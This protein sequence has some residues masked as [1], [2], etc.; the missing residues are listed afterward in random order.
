MRGRVL[1]SGCLVVAGLLCLQV[2]CA[3][4]GQPAS[5]QPI[6]IGVSAPLTG[7]LAVW[8]NNTLRGIQLAADEVNAAGGVSGRKIELVV[9]DSRCEPEEAVK[10]LRSFIEA[11]HIQVVLGADCSADVLAMAPVAQDKQVVLFS[12]GASNPEI[13]HAGDFVFRNWP[14]DALQ[15][16][17]TARYARDIGGFRRA[18]I[19]YVDNAY[20]Q[21]LD[22]VFRREFEA[23]G[24]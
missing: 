21:G 1:S 24:W 23:M 14:S 22:D 9:E 7:S 5:N 17:L 20:G 15:G 13:S 16:R 2:A 8:G 3:P 11:R 12:T 6:E 4:K 10:I 19:L 18:A